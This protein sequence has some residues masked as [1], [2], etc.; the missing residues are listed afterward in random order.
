MSFV[1]ERVPPQVLRVHD[2]VYRKTN[3]WIGHRTLWICE[4]IAGSDNA[5]HHMTRAAVVNADPAPTRC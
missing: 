1:E 2:A 5:V 4:F 3:G